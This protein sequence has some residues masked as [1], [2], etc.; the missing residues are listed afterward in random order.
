VRFSATRPWV[1]LTLVGGLLAGCFSVRSSQTP[2]PAT[3]QGSHLGGITL[4]VFADDDARRAGTVSTAGLVTELEQ[5]KQGTWSAV[6]SSL[7]PVW[8][9]MGLEPGVYRLR[10]PARLNDQGYAVENAE[11][12]RTIRVRAGR[13]TEV[14]ATLEHVSA[15][16][17]AAGVVTAVVAAVLLHEWL[18]DHDLPTPPLP[19]PHEVAEVAFWI[20]LD[21]A[22]SSDW[23]VVPVPPHGPVVTSHFPRDGALVAAP[24]VR[25]VFALSRPARG[26]LRGEDPITVIARESGPIPGHAT[27]DHGHSWL[28]WESDDDL[29]RGD[30]FEVT[31]AADAIEPGW[32]QPLRFSFRT[33]P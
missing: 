24:R 16:L 19:M 8:T 10:F 33:T 22:T 11:R 21:V 28:V 15:P 2:V 12:P 13:I 30:H 14:D 20:G 25:I 17:V 3:A 7:D 32:E 9:V 4:R 6:F 23:T 31:L 5:R 26:P 29:P 27:L 18:D 1:A